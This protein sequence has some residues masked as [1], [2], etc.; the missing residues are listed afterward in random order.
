MCACSGAQNYFPDRSFVTIAGRACADPVVEDFA[1]L[2]CTAPAGPGLGVVLNVSGLTVTSHLFSYDPPVV[3]AVTPSLISADANVA[4]EVFGSNLGL[5]NFGP[6]PV[7]YIGEHV[8]FRE[9][10]FFYNQ[11]MH[12]RCDGFVCVLCILF[13]GL[14]QVK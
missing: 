10:W 8:A 4:I 2:T 5:K 12:M 13:V 9:R 14:G 7:V 11:Y 6:D 3:T 1:R